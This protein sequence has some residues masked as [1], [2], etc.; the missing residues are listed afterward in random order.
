MISGTLPFHCIPLRLPTD[1]RE[2]FGPFVDSH[3]IDH[4]SCVGV[5]VTPQLSRMK[6]QLSLTAE[7]VPRIDFIFVVAKLRL[8]FTIAIAH[9][10]GVDQAT[11]A[12]L[13]FEFDISQDPCPIYRFHGKPFLV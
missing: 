4:P 13:R 3:E 7:V 8:G 9:N 12:A 6:R 1:G 2:T 11:R 5:H 10:G